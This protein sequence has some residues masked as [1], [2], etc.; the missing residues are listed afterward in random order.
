MIVK[1]VTRANV[2]D[3][4]DVKDVTRADVKENVA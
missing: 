1:D 4:T 3:V 2:K